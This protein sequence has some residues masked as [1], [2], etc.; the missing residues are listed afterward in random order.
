MIA[1][2]ICYT[3]QHQVDQHC[4]PCASNT[5]QKVYGT[6]RCENA[7]K[8]SV[9]PENVVHVQPCK[10]MQGGKHI[11]HAKGINTVVKNIPHLHII[12]PLMMDIHIRSHIGI[13]AQKRSKP[14]YHQ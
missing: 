2:K 3:I 4:R 8:R 10:Q 9:I 5:A 7:V 1:C 6:C 13:T 12:D 14:P 11:V